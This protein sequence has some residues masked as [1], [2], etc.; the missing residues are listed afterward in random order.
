[1]SPSWVEIEDYRCPQGS[2]GEAE[3]R[4]RACCRLL[5]RGEI[6]VLRELPFDLPAADREF[7]LA[8]RQTGSPFHKNVSY[9]PVQ[10][11]LRGIS[12]GSQADIARMQAIMRS[13]SLQVTDF[14][15][16]FLAPYAGRR[17]LD[18]ASF[19]PLE[20]KGRDLP[21]HKRNDLL[22]VDA[23]PTRPTRGGRILRVFTNINPAEPRV[24]LTG[25]PLHQMARTYA[26]HAGLARY[27]EAARSPL[28]P[29]LRS[30]RRV[31][32]KVGIPSPD[33]SA[34][35]AFMLHFHDWLKENANFQDKAAKA[36]HEFPPG[37]TWLVFTDGVPHA[38]L[39]GQFALEQTYIIPREALV[40]PEVAPIAVLE[41]LSGVALSA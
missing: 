1:M 34:Y 29:L 6:L 21:L 37:A 38:A 10:D 3:T 16:R 27:A 23:F 18:Y 14:L 26:S 25:P 24:W 17:I 20:E 8:Q 12:S 4:A 35:D 2:I 7:L 36:R 13:Y 32:G 39:S 28:R 40:E 31:L 15:T 9:R 33:R 30:A 41:Q 5:E 22:H 11:V 19:R